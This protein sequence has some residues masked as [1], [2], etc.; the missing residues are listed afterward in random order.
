MTESLWLEETFKITKSNHSLYTARVPKTKIEMSIHISK[1]KA[2]NLSKTLN[3]AI[4]PET[5]LHERLMN[6][7]KVCLK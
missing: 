6:M 2:S 7:A 5:C 3:V 4:K 1:Y